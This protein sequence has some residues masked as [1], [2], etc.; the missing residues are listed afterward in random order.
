ML[1]CTG[2]IAVSFGYFGGARI[3]PI[4]LADVKCSG[5]ES[6]LTACNHKTGSHNCEHKED[7]GVICKGKYTQCVRQVCHVYMEVKYN[8]FTVN[9]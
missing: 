7:A 4:L 5:R 6:S 2:A 9:H 1:D 3:D 8:G